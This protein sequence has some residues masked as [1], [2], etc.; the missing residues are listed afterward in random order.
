[1]AAKAKVS[2]INAEVRNDEVIS[3]PTPTATQSGGQANTESIVGMISKAIAKIFTDSAEFFGKVIFRGDVNFAGTPTFNKDTAGFAIIKSDSN[4]VEVKF[5]KE[6]A[7]EP[8]VTISINI[9]GDV[10]ISDMPNYVVADVNTKGFKIRASRVMGMDVRYSWTAIAVDDANQ[11]ISSGG[12][13]NTPTQIATPTI[14]ITPAATPSPSVDASPSATPTPEVSAT[15][16]P[17]IVITPTVTQE[18]EA[19]GSGAL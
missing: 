13:V 17:I 19:S 1:M 12:V 14:V 9:A 8:V 10:N 7:D 3:A 18:P 2:D 11:S 6:Y 4:E 15:P 5:E 16:T